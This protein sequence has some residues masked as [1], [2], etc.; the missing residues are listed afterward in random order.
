MSA[1][2]RD[3]ENETGGLLNRWICLLNV[4]LLLLLLCSLLGKGGPSPWDILALKGHSEVQINN[5]SGILD[6]QLG[7]LPK[8]R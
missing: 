1:A 3:N 5:G 2:K 4:T 8:I 7:F 6:P